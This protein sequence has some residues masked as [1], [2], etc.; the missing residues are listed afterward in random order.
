MNTENSVEMLRIV[1]SRQVQAARVR[2]LVPVLLLMC[3]TVSRGAAAQELSPYNCPQLRTIEMTRQ[4]IEALRAQREAGID[5]LPTARH[6][7][8]A[9]ESLYR[10]YWARLARLEDQQRQVEQ[11]CRSAQIR[12]EAGITR[13]SPLPEPYP[14][15]TDPFGGYP[16]QAE[17]QMYPYRDGWTYSPYAN[18]TRVYSPYRSRR[19]GGTYDPGAQVV[20]PYDPFRP[21]WQR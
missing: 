12:P 21:G 4:R 13:M 8:L 7:Q 15:S 9:N 20:Y 19:G 16:P 5:R 2:S 1:A 18:R 17:P 3:L 6:Q 14:Y 11:Y 10:W